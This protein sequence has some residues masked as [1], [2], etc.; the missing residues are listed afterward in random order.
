MSE[1]PPISVKLTRSSLNITDCPPEL[2]DALRFT[3]Y[4][5]THSDGN[6]TQ[7]P[8][9]V[10]FAAYDPRARIC[11]T[12]PNVLH[13]V[14]QRAREL[15]QTLDI[16][17]QRTFPELDLNQVD[18]SKI[19][20]GAFDALKTVAAAKASGLIVGPSGVGKL[21]IICGLVRMVPKNFKILVTTEDRNAAIQLHKALVSAL[22]E[23][24]VALHCKP[25]FE[26]GRVLVTVLDA[27]KD[28]TQG[29]DLAYSGYGL[30]D[31]DVWICD[32]VH[33][34]PVPARSPFLNQFRTVYSWGLTATPVRADNSHLL[35]EVVFG[36]VI[37]STI[38][39][40]VPAPVKVLVFPLP[41][42]AT[43]STERKLFSQIKATYVKNPFIRPSLI[44]ILSSLPDLD[45]AKI[46]IYVDTRAL[47]RRIAKDIPGFTFVHGLHSLEYRQDV[48]AKFKSG[49]IAKLICTDISS[50]GIDAPDIAC[51]IDCSADVH[52]NRIIHQ[53]GHGAGKNQ[54]ARYVMFLSTTSEYFFNQGVRKLQK[55]GAMDWDIQ[56]LFPRTLIRDLPFERAPLLPELGRF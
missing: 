25:T 28:F 41:T 29:V 44:A 54:P 1:L 8:V 17:D 55:I 9:P 37:F 6:F 46:L 39:Q 47:G 50:T 18:K 14:Q 19:P 15:H 27:L 43:I 56:F 48:L 34:L 30:R 24:K 51:V 4:D 11:R 10:V 23:E 16:A 49:E 35:N 22:P 45:I 52:P 3:R 36:P 38:R 40:E 5:I 7:S 53:A 2:A 13:L 12:Y 33:R 21:S 31:F 26:I 32:E 42:P 20:A